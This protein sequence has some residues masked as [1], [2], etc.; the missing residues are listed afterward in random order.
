MGRCRER[1]SGSR[2]PWGAERTTGKT[3]NGESALRG[4]QGDSN[5]P[6]ADQYSVGTP[7]A[8]FGS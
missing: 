3:V 8:F 5:I 1:G 6:K 2:R 7:R 4:G